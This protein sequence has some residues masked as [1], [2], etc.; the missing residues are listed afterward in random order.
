MQATRLDERLRQLESDLVA[1][2][3]R[4]SAYSELPCALFRYEPA[5]EWELRRELQKLAT[6]L[7]NHGRT[8][9]MVSLAEFVWRA[10]DEIEGLEPIL[11]LEKARGW[12][13]AQRQVNVY[14]S[15]PDFLCLP[16]AIAERAADLRPATDIV[17]L[18]RA[19]TLSPGIYLLS[20]LLDEL[21][22]QLA[23]PTVLFYPGIF[24]EHGLR[25]MGLTSRETTT[26][27]RVKIYQ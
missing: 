10:I 7:E 1:D 26:N 4:I 21:K 16:R 3:P 17:F 18:W 11:E 8:V 13:A 12:E 25:F 23:V 19:A 2:P 20:K 24:D 6:R 14:L 5:A 27:Y 22:G 9:H 15:D